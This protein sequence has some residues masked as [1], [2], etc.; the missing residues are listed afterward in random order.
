MS[1]WNQRIFIE[2]GRSGRLGD[3]STLVGGIV[4][5]LLPGMTGAQAGATFLQTQQTLAQEEL[6]RSKARQR[7]IV[8]G[9]AAAAATVGILA[10]ALTRR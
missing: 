8:I 1:G 5:S 4:G 3:V 10:L 2:P 9:A 6:Q 7:T